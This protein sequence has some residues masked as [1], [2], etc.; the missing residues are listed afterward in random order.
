MMARAL[1]VVAA[2]FACV[3]GV[4]TSREPSEL[5]IPAGARPFEEATALKAGA[6][7]QQTASSTYKM[8]ISG[9]LKAPLPLTSPPPAAPSPDNTTSNGTVCFAPYVFT[10]IMDSVGTTKETM[11][12]TVDLGGRATTIVTLCL[13]LGASLLLLL[14]GEQLVHTAVLLITEITTFTLWL[15]LFIWILQDSTAEFMECYWPFVVAVVLSLFTTLLAYCFLRKVECLAFF[16]LGAAGAAI[17]MYV[18]RDIIIS[19]AP[20]VVA[21]KEFHTYW[22]ALFVVSLGCGLVAAWFQTSMLITVTC[23]VGAYGVASAT[24]GLVPSTANVFPAP[25]IFWLTFGFALAV[26]FAVQCL[27]SKTK[28]EKGW[29]RNTLVCCCFAV[30]YDD[31]AKKQ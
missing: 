12:Y 2:L 15:Y 18:I 22:I 5:G 21:E 13:L 30:G 4:P 19:V 26:G 3:A 11:A 29:G 23:L 10:A 28:R 31:N 25:W 24:I 27:Q 6:P 20:S 8:Q 9:V 16:I 17:C 7:V 14:F 1:H